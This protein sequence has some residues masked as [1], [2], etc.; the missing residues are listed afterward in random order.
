MNSSE[1]SSEQT[2][3][4]RGGFSLLEVMVAITL[5]AVIL[6]ALTGASFSLV[7]YS[8]ISGGMV[9]RGAAAAEFAGYLTSAPWDSLPTAS[10][11]TSVA[12]PGFPHD[13]C[14][15]VVELNPNAKRFTV[16]IVPANTHIP[17]DSSVV[18]RGK[19]GG[20]NPFNNP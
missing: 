16:I 1:Q 10:E 15:T 18:Q 17:P 14:V 6:T 9:Q 19:G 20:G 2:S 4:K 8:Q 7:R 5:L 11:C 3:L 13:R 12:D